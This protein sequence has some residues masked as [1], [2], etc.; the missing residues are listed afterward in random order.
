MT[1]ELLGRGWTFPLLPGPEG[2]LEYAEGDAAVE[3]SLRVVLL[4]RLG[5]RPM[6]PGFGSGVPDAVFAPGSTRY[7]GLIEEAVREAVRD[8]EPRVDLLRARAEVDPEEPA[9]ITVSIDYLVRRTNSRQN[10]VFP[11]YLG[12]AGGR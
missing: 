11:F 7:L 5:E 3:Q 10:L 9:R 8:W 4:T 1:N 12:D 6:R 2:G